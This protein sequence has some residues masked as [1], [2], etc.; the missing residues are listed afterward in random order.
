MLLVVI[1]R[2]PGA[3]VKGVKGKMPEP[4]KQQK[5]RYQASEKET[6]D[7][8][9]TVGQNIQMWR[10]VF[11]WSQEELARSVGV[12]VFTVQKWEQGKM[13]PRPEALIA[14]GKAFDLKPADFLR[15]EPA[16]ESMIEAR[17]K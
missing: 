16:D 8:S 4:A 10:R 11:Q 3:A 13:M 1:I 2:V 5:A 15:I 9:M 12:S 7:F 17:K 6:R 14:L